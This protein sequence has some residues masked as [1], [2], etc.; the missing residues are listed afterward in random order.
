MPETYQLAGNAVRID[1][2]IRKGSEISSFYDPMIAKL[3]VHASS[4][5]AALRKLTVALEQTAIAGL[6]TNIGFLHAL[7]THQTF[8]AGPPSTNFI[9]QQIDSLLAD[10]DS[11]HNTACA[12]AATA[13][14]LSQLGDEHAT[15]WDKLLG[16]SLNNARCYKLPFVD[17]TVQLTSYCAVTDTFTITLGDERFDIAAK[18]DSE[19]VSATING[20]KFIAHY[21]IK[22]DELTLIQQGR[23]YYFTLTNKHYI[24]AKKDDEGSLTAPLNGTVVKCMV[25]P[26]TQVTKGDA[27]IIIEAMKMEYVLKAPTDG[28]ITQFYYQAGDLVSHG[29]LLAELQVAEHDS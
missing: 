15:P 23:S 20:T 18:I 4:R 5:Q 13:Y 7:A 26:N 3:I 11:D 22:N 8:V 10:S 6:H 2:G 1:T 12:L 9:D 28:V 14:I 27:V 21:L 29:A 19:T 16:F 25:E 24:A 17:E